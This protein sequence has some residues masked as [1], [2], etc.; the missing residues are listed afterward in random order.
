MWFLQVLQ[1]SIK[2]GIPKEIILDNGKDY[3][4]KDLFVNSGVRENLDFNIKS[5]LVILKT[6]RGTILGFTDGYCGSLYSSL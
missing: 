4:S 3:K 1:R 5:Y 6:V 2:Y